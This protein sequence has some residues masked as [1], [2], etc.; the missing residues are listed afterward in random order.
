MNRELRT[1]KLVKNGQDT[2]LTKESRQGRELKQW[3]SF[4]AGVLF[5]TLSQSGWANDGYVCEIKSAS[6]LNNV[7][8]IVKSEAYSNTAGTKFS[9][10]RNSGEVVGKWLK[11]GDFND[12]LVLDRGSDEWSFKLVA[13][14]RETP[15]NGIL[16]YI[17]IE[18]FADGKLKPFWAHRLGIIYSGMCENI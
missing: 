2:C 3:V 8:E 14:Y 4:V 10:D 15:D 11:T 6:S 16:M 1:F 17:S 13:V 12:P 7:G 9:V 5:L 18:E